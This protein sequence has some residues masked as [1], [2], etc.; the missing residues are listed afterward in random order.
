MFLDCN[1]IVPD[2]LWVG[3]FVRT[4]NVPFLKR[5]EI[6]TIVS[7][8]SNAD[9]R[10]LGRSYE[11]QLI[12]AYAESGM[13]LSRIPVLDFD[14]EDLAKNLPRCVAEVVWALTPRWTRVYLHCTAGITRSPTVAAAY[15]VRSHG[16]SVQEAFDHVTS[17]RHCSPHLGVLEEYAASLKLA[18]E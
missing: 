11:K 2:R 16:M 12:K 4:E 6:T 7:L 17:R 1:A 8:Q 5:M 9:I 15:L 14:S 3:Q 13:E 10:K 18:S